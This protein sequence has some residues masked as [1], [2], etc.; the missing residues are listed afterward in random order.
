M[1]RHFIT[2]LAL[3]FSLVVYSQETSFSVE[4][5]DLGFYDK[6]GNYGGFDGGIGYFKLQIDNV[7][8]TDSELK[9]IGTIVDQETGES[10]C[11]IK[12]FIGKRNEENVMSEKEFE[13]DCSGNFEIVTSFENENKLYF[14]MIGYSL[15]ECEIIVNQNYHC[16][17]EVIK[18]IR[19]NPEKVNSEMIL[20][21]LKSF[22]ESCK[23]NAEYS[24]AANWNLFYFLNEY[25]D[26]TMQLIENTQS[27]TEVDTDWIILQFKMPVNDGIDIKTIYEKVKNRKQTEISER[28][29][30]NLKLAA[31]GM[32]IELN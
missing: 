17:I 2:L 30:S 8:Q 15:L 24:Q 22:Q 13:V 32:D 5:T 1:N 3:F 10:F 4:K 31:K 18:D 28:I 21:F 29:L 12:A 7:K 14:K 6:S 19:R 26:M 16:D 23:N 27:D 20:K 9:I 11:G 25:T